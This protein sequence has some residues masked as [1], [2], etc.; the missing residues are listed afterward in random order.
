MSVVL[1]PVARQVSETR[2]YRFRTL[3][4]VLILYLISDIITSARFW[5]YHVTRDV[6]FVKMSDDNADIT[7]S[8]YF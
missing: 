5:R 1:G 8:V 6:I 7:F 4:G 3:S 2:Y